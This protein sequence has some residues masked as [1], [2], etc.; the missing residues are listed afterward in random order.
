[1]LFNSYVFVFLFFPLCLVGFYSCKKLGKALYA[2]AF[3]VLMSLWFYSFADV[4]NL[5]VLLVSMAVNYGIFCDMQNALKR[6]EKKGRLWLAMG[7]ACQVASLIFF[8]YTGSPFVPLAISFFTFSQIAFL[9]EGY[10]G[11]VKQTGLLDYAF[12]ITFFPKLIQ[13]PIALPAEIEGQVERAVEKPFEWEDFYRNLC[14]FILG[15][16]KKVLLAD[17][18]GSAVNLGYTSLAS[19]NTKDA[20]VVILSYTLQ[21]YFDF[22]G[23]SDMAMGAAGMLGF[24]LPV[25]FASPYKAANILEFWKGWHISLTRFFTKYLY[26]PLGGSRKGKERTYINIL[27]VFLLSGIWHGAGLT[28]IIWGMMHGVLNVITRWWQEKKGNRKEAVCKEE[29]N[30]KKYGQESYESKCGIWEKGKHILA[31]AATFLY[32][33][34]AWV[35]FRAP[36]VKEAF[37]LLKEAFSLSFGRMNKNLAGCFNLE[38]FWYVI[39]IFGLDNWQYAHYILMILFLTVAL[40]IVFC[41]KTA[42]QISREVKPGIIVTTAMAILFVWCVITFS[43]VSTFLYV[44]F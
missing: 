31:I 28:F 37:M 27:I 39:K 40:L 3:L 44:N 16:S 23:Y 41:G 26:I 9:V 1:M 5:P 35:F 13:G 22:S 42:L 2:K 4:R 36:S 7:V 12:Y 17:T 24:S 6:E 34:I 25:N 32:V 18:F 38:E 11:T 20:W 43:Q 8:K 29:E 33:N 30:R 15:L 21:L 14:L 10:K 19:L